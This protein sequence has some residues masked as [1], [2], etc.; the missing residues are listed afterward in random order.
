[1]DLSDLRPTFLMSLVADFLLMSYLFADVCE[2]A[3][4]VVSSQFLHLADIF[5]G[6]SHRRGTTMLL[7][8]VCG[9]SGLDGLED[10]AD[11]QLADADHLGDVVNAVPGI[12]KGP[13]ALTALSLLLICQVMFVGM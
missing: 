4:W 10:L 3:V 9:S 1:M 5:R 2:A 11:R 12:V 7:G 8:D 6:D 13:D